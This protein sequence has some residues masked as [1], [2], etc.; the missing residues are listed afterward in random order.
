MTQLVRSLVA[1]NAKILEVSAEEPEAHSQ[2]IHIDGS[3]QAERNLSKHVPP[4]I[5][6][7]VLQPEDT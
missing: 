7:S 6:A 5:S 3:A 2:T 1:A 4:T